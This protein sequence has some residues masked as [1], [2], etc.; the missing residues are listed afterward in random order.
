VTP[1]P[2][3]GSAPDASPGTETAGDAAVAPTTDRGPGGDRDPGA[4]GSAKLD[5]ATATTVCKLIAECSGVSK[6]SGAECVAS[7]VGYVDRLAGCG[8]Q[9]LASAYVAWFR[10]QAGSAVC[11]DRI[12]APPAGVCQ[13]EEDLVLQQRAAVGGACEEVSDKSAPGGKDS[14]SAR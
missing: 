2:E 10:C 6:L 12:V 4:D 9:E 13:K 11:K 8:G 5:E 14:S 3:N 7:L 1:A